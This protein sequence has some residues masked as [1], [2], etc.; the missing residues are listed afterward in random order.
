MLREEFDDWAILFNPDTGR[1]FGLS[2]TGVYVWKLLDGEHS[3]DEMLKALRRNVKDV[4][5]EADAQL[6]A[7]VEDLTKHGLA[8][9][10]AEKALPDGQRIN[11]PL[12]TSMPR[13][14]AGA[15]KRAYD[16]PKLIN[17]GAE[18]AYGGC[19][20]GSFNTNSPSCQTGNHTTVAC[21]FNGNVASGG[22]CE[23]GTSPASGCQYCYQGC[24]VTSW[25]GPCSPACN[26]GTQPGAYRWLGYLL[27]KIQ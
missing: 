3:I 22:Y 10:E 21:M 20:D 27:E 25:R 14:D 6:F 2:P 8:A 16:A 18:P 1:G 19:G 5:K 15:M 7:F 11:L 4:P 26:C 13:S 9:H 24:T 17:L 23:T 12:A